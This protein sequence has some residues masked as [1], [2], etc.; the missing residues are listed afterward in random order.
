MSDASTINLLR[1][2]GVI[3]ELF[4]MSLLNNTGVEDPFWV[5]YC[6]LKRK[7][8]TPPPYGDL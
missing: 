5:L 1:L 4:E 6:Y 8:P 3:P 7:E 2:R